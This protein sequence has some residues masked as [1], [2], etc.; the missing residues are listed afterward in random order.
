MPIRFTHTPAGSAVLGSLCAHLC[1]FELLLGAKVG[2]VTTLLLAAVGGTRVVTSIALATDEL[3]LLEFT[4]ESHEGRVDDSSTQAEHQ[5][6]SGLLLDVVVLECATILELL[7]RE[8]ET[9]LIRGDAFLILNL[10]LDSLNG[11]GSL[12]LEGDGLP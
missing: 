8:D 5:V 4:S 6:Q 10:G 9:L 12:H 2:G 7:A 3:V 1:L 11:V